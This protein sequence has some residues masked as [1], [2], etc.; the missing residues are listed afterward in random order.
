MHNRYTPL[1]FSNVPGYPNQSRKHRSTEGIS[2]FH[3]HEDAAIE[4][5]AKFK[6]HLITVGILIPS[7]P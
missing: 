5:I 1:D 7:R 6:E 3:Q 4:H 2:I